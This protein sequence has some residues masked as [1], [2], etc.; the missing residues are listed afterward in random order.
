VKV[1]K[2]HFQDALG[3][4]DARGFLNRLCIVLEEKPSEQ[5]RRA[6][7]NESLG[8]CFEQMANSGLFR[9]GHLI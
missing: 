2:G 6:R 5:E 7:C 1:I 4:G 8:E 3:D 9:L